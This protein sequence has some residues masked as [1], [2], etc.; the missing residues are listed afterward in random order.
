MSFICVAFICSP[1]K[2][3]CSD[4]TK[5]FLNSN[6][7]VK[8]RI[9]HT[10]WLG[11]ECN[12]TYQGEILP[13]TIQQFVCHARNSCLL[14]QNTGFPHSSVSKEFACNAG[15]LGSILGLGR[16]PGEGNGNL[17]QYSCLENPL[18]RGAWQ[19]IVHGV[20]RV[21][22]DLANKPPSSPEQNTKF[23]EEDMLISIHRW[24]ILLLGVLTSESLSEQA[25]FHGELLAG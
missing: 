25:W 12:K 23:Y 1:L 14:E 21:G 13:C 8:S 6:D 3:L 19:T 22:H 18:D 15:D 9:S 10:I 2:L 16:S 5:L 20:T 24:S 7:S 17:L 4:I 11:R